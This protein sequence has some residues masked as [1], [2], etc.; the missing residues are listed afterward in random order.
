ML[1][2]LFV[3]NTVVSTVRIEKEVQKF[4]CSWKFE[5]LDINT[6]SWIQQNDISLSLGGT[7]EDI[8]VTESTGSTVAGRVSP[9]GAGSVSQ[10]Q[11]SGAGVAGDVFTEKGGL[12]LL[13]VERKRGEPSNQEKAASK[14]GGG[15]EREHWGCSKMGQTG[16]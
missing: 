2:C 9:Q 3:I 1:G 7:E 5:R 14:A 15:T 13:V 8:V 11:R 6:S 12:E 16:E 10:P 4:L